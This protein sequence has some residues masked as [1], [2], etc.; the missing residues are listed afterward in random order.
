[1]S[2]EPDDPNR[3]GRMKPP[4]QMHM[5]DLFIREVVKRTRELGIESGRIRGDYKD[6]MRYAWMS[7]CDIHYSECQLVEEKLDPYRT[8]WFFAE[9]LPR[10][11]IFAGHYQTLMQE[12]DQARDEACQLRNTIAALKSEIANLRGERE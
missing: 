2:V 4:R 1:M 12:R 6:F 3:P 8:T 9:K 10:D 7:E 11:I 5:D